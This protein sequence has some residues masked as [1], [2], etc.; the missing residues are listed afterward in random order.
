MGESW[1]HAVIKNITTQPHSDLLS[2]MVISLQVA[3]VLAFQLANVNVTFS[4]PNF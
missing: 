1:L 4:I 3:C 2:H